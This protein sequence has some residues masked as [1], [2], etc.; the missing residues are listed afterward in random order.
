[1]V[2][3]NN[4]E[5]KERWTPPDSTLLQLSI[6]NKIVN[7]PTAKY[8]QL[9][10]LKKYRTGTKLE[11]QGEHGLGETFYPSEDYPHWLIVKLYLPLDS[12]IEKFK[13][14]MA[15]KNNTSFDRLGVKLPD[16]FVME[17]EAPKLYPAEVR[18]Q[19]IDSINASPRKVLKS[20][21]TPDNKTHFYLLTDKNWSVVDGE[22]SK[23][24][25]ITIKLKK[26]LNDY[27]YL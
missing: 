14:V 12:K 3:E 17:V 25:S 24:S 7:T 8:L 13:N 27:N 19:V 1:M 6:R 20:I 23:D 10:I 2:M 16:S 5:K 26:L 22:P 11:F 18:K 15:R 9:R 21:Y 4:E